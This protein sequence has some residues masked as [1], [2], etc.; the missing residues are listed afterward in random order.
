MLQ[1][2]IRKIRGHSFEVHESPRS[3]SERIELR[4]RHRLERLKQAMLQLDPSSEEYKN[5]QREYFA[6]GGE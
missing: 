5:L 2:L 3:P 1:A 6:R 4:N